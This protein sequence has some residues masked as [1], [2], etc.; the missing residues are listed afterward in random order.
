MRRRWTVRIALWIAVPAVAL[1]TACSHAAHSA[2]SAAPAAGVAPRPATGAPVESGA[3]GS[4]ASSATG[5]AATGKTA[6]PNSAQLDGLLG[7]PSLIKTVQLSVTTRDVAA[8]ADRAESIA[9]AAGGS[10]DGDDRTSGSRP[11]AELTLRV[12]PASLGQVLGRLSALGTEV[13]RTLSTRDVTTAV[14]DV[15]SRVRSAQAA[16]D[17]LRALFGKATQV[18]DLISIESELAQR[19]ADLESLQ[20]QQRALNAQVQLAT[21]TVELNS[22]GP[23][24]PVRHRAHT[25]GFVGGLKRGWHAFTTGATGVVTALAA[26]LP[27][28]VL[29]A[30]VAA[31]A[32][33][34]RR[35]INSRVRTPRAPKPSA[36]AS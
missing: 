4:N 15:D 36:D 31:A 22:P 17:Q 33:Y 26:T 11:T 19:E 23:P 9:L 20:A 12:P 16:I 8:A 34:A 18:E 2:R 27:F 25:S 28:L 21:V 24:P 6:A 3:G 30:A 1:L 10:V 13:S 29:L 14:A 35:M 7:G 5:R 32:H